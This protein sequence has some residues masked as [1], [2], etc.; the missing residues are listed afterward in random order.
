MKVLGNQRTNHINKNIKKSLHYSWLDVVSAAGQLTD[1]PKAKAMAQRLLENNAYR[2]RLSNDRPDQVFG[3]SSR[4][5]IALVSAYACFLQDPVNRVDGD[6]PAHEVKKEAK[7]V[8]S[9]YAAQISY[10][11]IVVRI[12]ILLNCKFV[13][14]THEFNQCT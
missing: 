11:E 1:T 5:R 14:N 13:Y 7:R 12:S 4:Y 3:S 9:L 10:F 6:P 8:R 2:H